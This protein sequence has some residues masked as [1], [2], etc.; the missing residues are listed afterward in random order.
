MHILS[1]DERN[2]LRGN[3]FRFMCNR[4]SYIVGDAFERDLYA[5]VDRHASL[6]EKKGLNGPAQALRNQLPQRTDPLYDT[7]TRAA[8]RL[9]EDI[10]TGRLAV[11]VV[12]GPDNA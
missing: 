12:E 6:L 2:I 8:L 11:V 3:I 4:V 5:G 10:K 7:N 9:Q 1:V